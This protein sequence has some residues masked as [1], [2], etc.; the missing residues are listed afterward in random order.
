MGS[1]ER[2]VNG[3]NTLTVFVKTYS[4]VLRTGQLFVHRIIFRDVGFGNLSLA[5]IFLLIKVLQLTTI[6]VSI[7]LVVYIL[8][9]FTGK[10]SI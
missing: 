3:Q 4:V 9:V 2:I 7:T 6:Q 10:R 1:F 5:V 8:H